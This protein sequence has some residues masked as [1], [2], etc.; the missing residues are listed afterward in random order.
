MLSFR[1]S[2]FFFFFWIFYCLFDEANDIRIGNLQ[3]SSIHFFIC[4]ANSFSVCL[5]WRVFMYSYN[6]I[7]IIETIQF[8]YCHKMIMTSVYATIL[9]IREYCSC[10]YVLCVY[11][12]CL[13]WCWWWDI[14]WKNI[15]IYVTTH[16][17]IARDG[18]LDGYCFHSFNEYHSCGVTLFHSYEMPQNDTS[19]F[20][21]SQFSRAF[22]MHRASFSFLGVC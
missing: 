19:P 14:S 15:H 16:E 9:G 20:C 8:I 12:C 4:F 7:H 22:R 11:V 3:I 5:K 10:H 6:E 13:C 17:T 18:L 1:I 2:R 21:I